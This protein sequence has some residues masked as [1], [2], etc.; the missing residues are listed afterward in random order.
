MPVPYINQR[1]ATKWHHVTAYKVLDL[2]V[3]IEDAPAHGTPDSLECVRPGLPCHQLQRNHSRRFVDGRANVLFF[4]Y[5]YFWLCDEHAAS[6]KNNPAKRTRCR[7]L[8][9]KRK[10][11]PKR[12]RMYKQLVRFGL[13]S[14]VGLFEARSDKNHGAW[15]TGVA[16]LLVSSNKNTKSLGNGI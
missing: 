15:P 5:Y 7:C 4:S 13:A 1:N 6:G 12:P 16:Q 2:N 3:W 14:L 10:Q 11:L 8:H 9:L